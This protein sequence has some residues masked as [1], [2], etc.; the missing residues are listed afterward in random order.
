MASSTMEE[1]QG[2]SQG[3]YHIKKLSR[4]NFF[5]WKFDMEMVLVGKDL[6]D[7]VTGEEVLDEGAPENVRKAFRKRENRALSTI[8][9]STSSDLKINVRNSNISCRK[10]SL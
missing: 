9:L 2:N 3:A 8:C 5:D 7:I 1:S 4:E 10:M 6:W